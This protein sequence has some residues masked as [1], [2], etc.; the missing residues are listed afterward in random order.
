MPPGEQ[1]GLISVLVQE[2]KRFVKCVWS[3]IL[4]GG[5][6]YFGTIADDDRS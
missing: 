1:V 5:W 6:F 4:K 2:R 3:L